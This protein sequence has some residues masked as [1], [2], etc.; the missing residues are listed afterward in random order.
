MCIRDSYNTRL[1]DNFATYLEDWANSERFKTLFNV[2]PNRQFNRQN[3][4]VYDEFKYDFSFSYAS[5]FTGLLSKIKLIVYS[6]Q[7][8]FARN[9]AGQ[10]NWISHVPFPFPEDVR[11]VQ[12]Q[13]W[14]LG[15]TVL[16]T[17]SVAGKTY[18]A[19]VYATGEHAPAQAPLPLSDLLRRFISGDRDWTK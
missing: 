3:R 19:V 14:K 4:S 18:F 8:D 1:Y 9:T 10:S 5:V 17:V 11:A 7:D 6:G 12:K 2:D 15:P 13:V 16:G